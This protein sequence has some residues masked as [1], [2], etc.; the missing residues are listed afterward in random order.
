MHKFLLLY[1][2]IFVNIIVPIVIYLLLH[3]PVFPF[4]V[5][6]L[7]QSPDFSIIFTAAFLF[8]VVNTETSKE[9]VI[10]VIYAKEETDASDLTQQMLFDFLSANVDDTYIVEKSGTVRL[11][12]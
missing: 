12:Q 9:E 2:L 3:Q 5:V 10:A 7:Y 4:S 8:T 1:I 11:C 6:T